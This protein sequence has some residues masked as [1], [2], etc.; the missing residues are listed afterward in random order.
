MNKR[1]VVIIGKLKEHDLFSAADLLKALKNI[2]VPIIP[3]DSNKMNVSFEDEKV[4]QKKPIHYKH[5]TRRK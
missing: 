5:V 1:V 3:A 2:D 4:L